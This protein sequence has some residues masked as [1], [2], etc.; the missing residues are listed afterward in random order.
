M[1]KSILKETLSD[2]KHWLGWI[3]TLIV[4]ILAFHYLGVHGLHKPFYNV[5]ILL[6]VIVIVD[7][8]KHLVKLQ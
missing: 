1:K 2:W 7:F 3:I 6:A 5:F 4:I 8:L